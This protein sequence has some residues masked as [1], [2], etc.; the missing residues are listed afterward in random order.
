V[1]REPQPTSVSSTHV[2]YQTSQINL[3]GNSQQSTGFDPRGDA[4]ELMRLTA[5]LQH[6]EKPSVF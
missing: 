3:R 2:N 5:Q 1:F 6:G 4:H